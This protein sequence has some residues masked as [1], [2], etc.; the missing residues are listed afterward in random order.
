MFFLVN[1]CTKMERQGRRKEGKHMISLERKFSVA[2]MMDSNYRER[3]DLQ[4]KG[5]RV[6]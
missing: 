3:Q 2:P 6:V 1:Q 5:F 4:N